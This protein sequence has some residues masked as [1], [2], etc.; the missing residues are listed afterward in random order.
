MKTNNI[1]S[2]A[3]LFSMLVVPRLMVSQE[4][5]LL[6]AMREVPQAG[7]ANPAY[8][9]PCK[10]HFSFLVPGLAVSAGHSGFAWEDLFTRRADDSLN[11]DVS[12]AIAKMKTNNY[13]T[14][15]F[16]Y[17]A[18]SFGIRF[19]KNYLSV[20]SNLR[21]DVAFQYPKRLF[22]LLDQGNAPFVGQEMDFD[23]LHFIGT[24]WV[25]NSISYTRQMSSKFNAGLRFKL[26]TGLANAHLAENQLK[27]ETDE[28]MY[29]LSFES[30]FLV[31]T[32]YPKEEDVYF[33]QSR[34][35]AF[36]FGISWTPVEELMIAAGVNDLGRIKWKENL[37]NYQSNDSAAFTF[38]GLELN[39]FFNTDEELESGFQALSDSLKDIFAIDEFSNIYTS[40][41]PTAYHLAVNY[42]FTDYDQLAAVFNMRQF[43]NQLIPSASLMY[44]HN[45]GRVFATTLAVSYHNQSFNNIG[46]GCSLNLG[47]LQLYA[48]S[49]N[50]LSGIIPERARNIG[51]QFGMNFLIGRLDKYKPPLTIIIEEDFWDEE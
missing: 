2:L 44:H 35:Y 19:E 4:S 31:N 14:S 1:A 34:G 6:H 25:E 33:P 10:A 17:E 47:F 50:I 29:D 36:D 49:G 9:P 46:L 20:S 11:L 16:R 5:L 42:R 39:D 32:S 18:L 30:D 43:E 23:K 12:K 26:L 45:F 22:E 15:T 40:P 51:V 48:L 3:L 13:L 41:L 28:D 7:W 38:S 37:V 8:I 21:T 24:A 27:F